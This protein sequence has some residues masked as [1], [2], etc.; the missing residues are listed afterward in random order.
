MRIQCHDT[1]HIFVVWSIRR[2]HWHRCR[3]GF[4]PSRDQSYIARGRPWLS[5]HCADILLR[6]LSD[7][8]DLAKH[9]AGS[10][11]SQLQSRHSIFHRAP[12]RFL[13]WRSNTWSLIVHRKCLWPRCSLSTRADTGTDRLVRAYWWLIC[14]SCILLNVVNPGLP[15]GTEAPVMTP[16]G[17]DFSFVFLV[18]ELS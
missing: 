17:V 10:L 5:H 11:H 6:P 3:R 1:Q 4:L 8:S 14:I 2:W 13:W 9:C 18:E 16:S 12:Y 7:S 15:L